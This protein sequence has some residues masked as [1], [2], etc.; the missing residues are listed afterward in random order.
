MERMHLDA[1]LW[2]RALHEG[3]AAGD[4]PVA[5][6]LAGLLE[7][8]RTWPE[9][10]DFLD[11]ASPNFRWKALETALYGDLWGDLF[12][13][14][15]L[16]VLDAACGSGR[17]LVPLAAAG[18]RVVGVDA[19]RPSLEAADRHLRARGLSAEL[20]WADVRTWSGGPFDRIVA[21]ELLCYVP[22][23]T[24]AAAHL[25]SLLKPGGTLVLTVEAW[26]GAL[27]ADPSGIAPADLPEVLR[28]RVLQQPGERWVRASDRADLG[29]ILRNAG[30]DVARIAG[31]HYLPDGPLG[32][33]LDLDRLDDEGYTAAVLAA[34]RAARD[35][36]AVAALPRAWLA[37]A[38]RTR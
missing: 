37:V 3:G 38:T 23:P 21:L 2:L 11:P 30:L 19:C 14:T 6:N 36:P 33:L 4:D 5:W 29:A 13:G 10:M 15:R 24:A 27:L 28:S 16:D 31:T 34:E 20:H 35:D 7:G 22:D 8:W 32:G 1:P 9:G 12:E 25:A 26:P 17:M 18:H